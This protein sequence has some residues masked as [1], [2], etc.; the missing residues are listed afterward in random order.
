MASKAKDRAD[1]PAGLGTEESRVLECFAGGAILA[2]DALVR[3]TGLP[4]HQLSATLMLLEL[5]RLVAKRV[6]GAFER[7]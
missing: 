2:P 3:L 6:D 1:A 4:S 7:R 5:K